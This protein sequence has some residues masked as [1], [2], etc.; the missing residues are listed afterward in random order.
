MKE[1]VSREPQITFTTEVIGKSVNGE[2][3]SIYSIRVNDKDEYLHIHAG[4]HGDEFQAV[5]ICELLLEKCKSGE[6]RPSVNIIFFPCINP[7]GRKAGES[8]TR[9]NSNNVDLNR[10]FPTENW[11]SEKSGYMKDKSRYFPG[12][13]GG[14]EPEV[15][16]VIQCIEKYKPLTVAALHTMETP[17]VNYDGPGEKLAAK[18]SELSG[19]KLEPDMGYA[20]P[21]SFGTWA[22]KERNIPII[23]YEFDEAKSSENLFSVNKEAFC[24]FIEEYF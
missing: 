2:D 24:Y 13:K 7:D 9:G 14:S 18:L 3:L 6:Y 16:A 1:E 5:E 10:N 21:G 19:Y 20:T 23:T 8:G 15:Q 12:E 4:I 22:G 17:L 11:C